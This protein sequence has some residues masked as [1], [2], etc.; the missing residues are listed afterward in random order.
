V[1]LEA[2]DGLEALRI[3]GQNDTRVDLV[4]LDVKMPGMSGWEVLAELKRRSPA[5]PV[6][7]TSGYTKEDSTPPPAAAV[8]DAY[9]PK[10]Y[11]LGELTAQ[12][13]QLLP[14]RPSADTGA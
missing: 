11:D 6:I 8:P 12:V 1:V 2:R 3:H 4:L 14:A 13:R 10:P 5:L 9:L 7:L